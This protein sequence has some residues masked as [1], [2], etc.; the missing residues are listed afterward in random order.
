MATVYAAEA[1][2]TRVRLGDLSG[3]PKDERQLVKKAGVDP[4]VASDQRGHGLGLSLELSK[5]G[6]EQKRAAVKK[7]ESAVLRQPP[8]ENGRAQANPA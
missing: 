5:L 8:P 7:L 6:H 4:K 3:A 2:E 1:G